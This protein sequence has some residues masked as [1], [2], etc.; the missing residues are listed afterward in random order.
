MDNR[1]IVRLK[2]SEGPKILMVQNSRDAEF[3]MAN[4]RQIPSIL[5]G[6]DSVGIAAV[7]ASGIQPPSGETIGAKTAQE[8]TELRPL[9][10]RGARRQGILILNEIAA[11]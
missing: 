7:E 8:S 5:R 10:K 3:F 6:N 4:L 1:L 11:G 2:K 9:S